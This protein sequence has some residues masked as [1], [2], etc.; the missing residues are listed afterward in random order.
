LLLFLLYE[1]VFHLAGTFVK[2]DCPF[3]QGLHDIIQAVKFYWL[4][5]KVTVLDPTIQLAVIY[6][7]QVAFNQWPHQIHFLTK[8][9][10]HLSR[11]NPISVQFCVV[12][13]QVLILTFPSFF[14]LRLDS[15]N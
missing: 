7:F 3:R 8:P 11:L 12:I 5:H 2:F 10:I 4:P 14:N 6:V 13:L 9:R 15:I 1:V